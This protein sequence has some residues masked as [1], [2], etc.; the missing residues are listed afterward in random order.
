MEK[1]KPSS[2]Y[3]AMTEI[4]KF[5]ILVMKTVF[6][7]FIKI[8]KWWKCKLKMKNFNLEKNN[9]S[10]RFTFWFTVMVV[11]NI[12]LFSS[13]LSQSL[14]DQN[15]KSKCNFF[16]YQIKYKC[17]VDDIFCNVKYRRDSPDP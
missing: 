12:F 16:S 2:S 14:G 3:S 13:N 6:V 11:K 7:V 4:N 9:N 5:A 10:L 15:K 8:Y 17:W 1:S